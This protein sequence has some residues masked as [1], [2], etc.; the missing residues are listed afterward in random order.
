MGFS[1]F[2]FQQHG[3]SG[4]WM[5][6]LM[7]HTAAPPSPGE[8]TKLVLVERLRLAADAPLA[9]DRAGLPHSIAEQMTALRLSMCETVGSRAKVLIRR[10]PGD[11]NPARRSR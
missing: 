3:N 8:D 10:V 11:I 7:P 9:V 1:I 2:D 4:A 5:S 6:N